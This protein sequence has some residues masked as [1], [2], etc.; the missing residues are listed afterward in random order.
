MSWAY[1]GREE[2]AQLGLVLVPKELE[3]A[4]PPNAHTRCRRMPGGGVRQIRGGGQE[5][6]DGRDQAMYEQDGEGYVRVCTKNTLR[7]R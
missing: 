4:P 3:N 7:E 5:R 6:R 2:V 1:R